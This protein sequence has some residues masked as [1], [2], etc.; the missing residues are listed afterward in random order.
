MASIGNKA[1]SK[2]M[3]ATLIYETRST[4]MLGICMAR[5][6]VITDRLVRIN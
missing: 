2:P 6:E 3:K 5:N 1:I 4:K